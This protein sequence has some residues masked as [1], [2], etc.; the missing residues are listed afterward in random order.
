MMSPQLTCQVCR[1]VI[2][3]RKIQ[4]DVSEWMKLNGAEIVGLIH[5]T[6]RVGE[7]L[8]AFGLRRR[9]E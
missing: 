7:H 9:L 3:P 1:M 8:I 6:T 2:E 5:T 4:D